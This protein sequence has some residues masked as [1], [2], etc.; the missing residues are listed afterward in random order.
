MDGDGLSLIYKRI[1]P[2]NGTMVVWENG[3][4][5]IPDGTDIPPELL[6][7]GADLGT[8]P[9]S[10]LYIHLSDLRVT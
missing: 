9:M 6:E 1:K 3:S 4:Q 8:W 2:K 5:F 7:A 10:S